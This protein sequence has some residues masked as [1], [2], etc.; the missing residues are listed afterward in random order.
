MTAKPAIK[1][2]C[3]RI[4]CVDPLSGLCLGC[5]RSLQEIGS[6]LAMSPEHRARIMAQLA[7]R[8]QHL[9]DSRPEAFDQ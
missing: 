1:S 9:R 7:E 8:L 3:V 4:C 2:P 5:G 6:W